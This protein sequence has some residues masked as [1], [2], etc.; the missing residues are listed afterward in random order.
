MGGED[1]GA[2]GVVGGGREW[3]EGHGA[4]HKL[5]LVHRGCYSNLNVIR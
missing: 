2:V 1:G 5:L 4:R 3:R